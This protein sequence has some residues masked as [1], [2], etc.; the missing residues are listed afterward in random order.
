MLENVRK[1]LRDLVKF[2]DKKARKIIYTDFEDEFSEAREVTLNGL[3]SATTSI[4]YKKKMLNFLISHEDHI[5]LHK[6]KQNV[7]ITQTD[8]DELKRLL[9]ESGDVGTQEDFER[10]YGKQEHLGL[11]IR[12]LVGLNRE[13]AKRVFSD[14]LNEHRFNSNQIQFINLIIDYLSQNGTIEPSKLYEPPYTDF[15]SNGLDGVFQDK[16]ADRIVGILRSIKDNA[17]A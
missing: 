13:A 4:Q 7:P 11:F 1:R 2:M 8:I 6:L 15:N 3:V 17:A 14:Y 9:F 12:S 10:A 16:D 5:V